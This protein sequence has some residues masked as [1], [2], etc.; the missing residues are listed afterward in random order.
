MYFR[1]STTNEFTVY[2][3]NENVK[4]AIESAL[5]DSYTAYGKAYNVTIICNTEWTSPE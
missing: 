4:S 1:D 3:R 5:E 2:G